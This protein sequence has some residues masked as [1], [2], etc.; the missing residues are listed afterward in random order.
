MKKLN[1]F[2]EILVKF[3]WVLAILAFFLHIILFDKGE[4]YAFVT[5]TIF[6]F[7]IYLAFDFQRLISF[8]KS[9]RLFLIFIFLALISSYFIWSNYSYEKFELSPIM[10]ISSYF[11]ILLFMGLAFPLMLIS[12]RHGKK[13]LAKIEENKKEKEWEDSFTKRGMAINFLVALSGKFNL[14][15]SECSYE[16]NKEALKILESNGYVSIT[17]LPDESRFV[18]LTYEGNK[19][20]REKLGGEFDFDV[21]TLSYAKLERYSKKLFK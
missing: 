18:L 8:K 10:E 17:K 11:I 2:Q 13:V 16:E 21:I 6:G 15:Y 12:E 20:M 19:K 5:S 14:R 1:I 3:L 7:S 4:Y 9:R